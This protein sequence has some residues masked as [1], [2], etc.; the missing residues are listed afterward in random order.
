MDVAQ[1]PA[2]CCI[3]NELSEKTDAAQPL[4]AILVEYVAR[5]GRQVKMNDSLSLIFSLDCLKIHAQNIEMICCRLPD[6]PGEKECLSIM[7]RFGMPDHVVRH[8]REVCRVALYLGRRLAARGLPLDLDL[9]RS[10]ALLHDITKKYSFSRPLD[11]ALTGAKLLRKL[12]LQDEA[13]IVRQ[14]VRLSAARSAGRIAEPEIVFYADKRVVEDR[15]T[16]LDDRLEYIR[17]RY[18]LSEAAL[19]RINLFSRAAYDVEY[20]IFSRLDGGPE[21]VMSLLQSEES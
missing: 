13:S 16:T 1:P 21:Q 19:K 9:I 20:H 12:G 5:L 4:D 8:S 18:G 17:K 6:R 2:R 14:H 7:A 3:Y 11:H 15:I 10:A